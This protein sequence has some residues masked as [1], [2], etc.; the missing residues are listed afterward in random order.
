M[1]EDHCPCTV[2][3]VHSP[4]LHSGGEYRQL[5]LCCDEAGGTLLHAG[6]GERRKRYNAFSGRV[7]GDA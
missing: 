3:E 5:L 2:P 6:L 1:Q 4:L 7:F